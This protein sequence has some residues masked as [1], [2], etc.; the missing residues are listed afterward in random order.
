MFFDDPVAAFANLRA[1]V[2]PGGRLAFVAWGPWPTSSGWR[3]PSGRRPPSSAGPR[4]ALAA[5][6]CC[7]SAT[8]TTWS[9]CSTRAGW[10]GVDVARHERS[11]VLGGARTVEAATDFVSS[12]GAMRGLFADADPDAAARATEAIRA[13]LQ[14]HLTSEGVVVSGGV[15]AV[16]ARR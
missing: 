11:M 6:P 14:D 8:A 4:S 13:A 16:T 2:R 5:R 12:T 1:A 9:T 15:L 10:E 3:S 7:R